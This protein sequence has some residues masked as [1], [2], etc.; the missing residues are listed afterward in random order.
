MM[1]KNC[2]CVECFQHEWLLVE[3][4]TDSLLFLQEDVWN[5]T[6]SRFLDLDH[7]YEEHHSYRK[8]SYDK[9]YLYWIPNLE[10]KR[11]HFYYELT[12]LPKLSHFHDLNRRTA[13][14]TS[15][16][17]NPFFWIPVSGVYIEKKLSL[18]LF[19]IMR[20]LK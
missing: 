9:G 10:L 11:A 1:C 2:T 12:S 19:Y 7:K 14:K 16:Q 18:F 20:S 5:Q 6:G 3:L 8:A 17:D 4:S 15:D 13:L